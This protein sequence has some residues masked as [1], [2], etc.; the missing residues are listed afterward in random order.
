VIAVVGIFSAEKTVQP[1]QAKHVEER[2]I[3]GE[4]LIKM[5]MRGVQPRW[6]Y[7]LDIACDVPA[8]EVFT[9]L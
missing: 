7:I 2:T 8:D 5:K 9:L 3:K 4:M 6:V 1:E